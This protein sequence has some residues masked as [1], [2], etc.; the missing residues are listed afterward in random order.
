MAVKLNHEALRK[1]QRAL[2][3]NWHFIISGVPTKLDGVSPFNTSSEEGKRLIGANGLLNLE[4]SSVSLPSSSI[5]MAST[6]LRGIM[7]QQPGIVSMSGS[8]S[9]SFLET[10]E[11]TVTRAFERLKQ[12][13]S[14]RESI[15]QGASKKKE[16]DTFMSH[17]FIALMDGEGVCRL[18]YQLLNVNLVDVQPSDPSQ[19]SDFVT[20]TTSWAFTNYRMWEFT[21]STY[22][23]IGG[24]Q[25]SIVTMENSLGKII[26]IT[27]GKVI[28]GPGGNSVAAIPLKED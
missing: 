26:T 1:P 24:M 15:I 25:D 28:D 9:A 7:V 4:C 16:D 3:H 13:T 2:T 23:Q 5:S 18:V 27:T 12:F 10:D 6:M 11:Y 8:I 14:D 17:V 22:Q 21:G 20:V 19:S